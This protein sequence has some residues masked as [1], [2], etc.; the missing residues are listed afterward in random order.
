MARGDSLFTG[1]DEADLLRQQQRLLGAL[2][3]A[4]ERGLK[5]RGEAYTKVDV[6]DMS[7]LCDEGFEKLLGQEGVGLLQRVVE[8]DALKRATCA[9]AASHP[10]L[11]EIV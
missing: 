9:Q 2:P 1:E 6:T 5:Q 11:S 4:V 10:F 7:N 3:K 8:M